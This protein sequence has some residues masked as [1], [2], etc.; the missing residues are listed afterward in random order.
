[1]SR[2]HLLETGIHINSSRLI[3]IKSEKKMFW[4]TFGT[5]C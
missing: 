4:Y 5:C 2:N 3:Q 1:M